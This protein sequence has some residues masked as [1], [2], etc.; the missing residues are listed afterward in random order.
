MDKFA[1]PADPAGDGSV[2]GAG[3]PATNGAVV[4]DPSGN[5]HVPAERVEVEGYAAA[6]PLYTERGWVGVLPL[7]PGKKKDPPKGYT[8]HTGKVPTPEQIARWGRTKP[9]G[10]IAL[11]LP[12]TVIGIDVDAYGDKTGGRTLAEA[13]S[14]WGELPPTVRSTSREDGVSGIRL[15]RVPAGTVLPGVIKLTLDDRTETGDIE[16]IQ[17]HHRYVIARPSIHPEGRLYQWLDENGQPTDIPAVDDAPDLPAGWLDGLAELAPGTNRTTKATEAPSGGTQ[18]EAETQVVQDGAVTEGAMSPRVLARLQ[19]ALAA[20]YGPSRFDTV[21]DHVLALVRYGEQGEPGVRVAG[22]A[23]REVYIAAVAED[24][25]GGEAAAAA[26]FD[27]HANG[28]L[29]LV[30][31][32]PTPDP[33][34]VNLLGDER[35]DWSHP[36]SG[37]EGDEQ[38]K[39]PPSNARVVI[40]MPVSQI[41]DD[42]P[43]WAWEYDGHG[44]MMLGTLVTLAGRPGAGKSTA[45]RWF[46]AGFTTGT[47]AGCFHGQPQNVAYVG[48]EE[49]WEYIVKPG[50]RAA[51]ADLDR[52]MKVFIEKSGMATRLL[53]A[54]DENA[55]IEAFCVGNVTVVI[56]DPLMSSI[57]GKVD[58]Y[59]NN[60]VR[61]VLEPWARIAQKINGLVIGVAHLIKAPGADVVAA[62]QGS[63]AF[64][65]VARAVFGLAKD[66]NDDR[67]MTQ[68][69]NSAG[70]EG[71][72][73][74][75]RIAVDEVVTDSGSPADAAR[76]E[77]T[78]TTDRTVSDIL[79]EQARGGGGR[80]GGAAEVALW[81]GTYLADGPRWAAPGY[82][83]AERA[84]FSE[85]RVKRAKQSAHIRSVRAEDRWYWATDAQIEAGMT[86]V[87]PPLDN[88][89]AFPAVEPQ[90][91]N[92]FPGPSTPDE[93]DTVDE[94]DDE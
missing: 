10:N 80:G 76:F 35:T 68:A 58:L 71:W 17:H 83:A 44:R 82:S 3:D 11:R 67:V 14:R 61:D 59:R 75:Y 9:Y 45:A 15:Y 48:T 7:P 2:A 38:E 84:G 29:H 18:A 25:D 86:P 70:P 66:T 94:G 1:T 23:L 26:E 79:R 27:R 52:V 46:A 40:L 77:I 12:D 88:I 47:H 13:Q 64:G 85:D 87:D 73:V 4:G 51:G 89:V 56:V 33:V 31:G 60:E 65:E 69:K 91:V 90:T 30:A 42:A 16:I 20:C 8:G 53:A 50:L 54:E 57:D 55:L 62:I 5:G 74:N 6:V 92:P 28:A 39:A 81:L 19:E 37:Q 34:T 63:S 93:G 43:T 24:R 22:A 32:D 72:S 36:P 49:S 21:R 41:K 78:G